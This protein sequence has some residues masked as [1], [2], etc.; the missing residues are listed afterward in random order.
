MTYK[1]KKRKRVRSMLYPKEPRWK[2]IS[3]FL[4]VELLSK[5]KKKE[6]KESKWEKSILEKKKHREKLEASLNF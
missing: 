4:V 6:F 5:L 2:K 3:S 1:N